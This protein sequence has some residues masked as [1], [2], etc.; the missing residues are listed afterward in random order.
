MFIEAEDI[1]NN[2]LIIK[3]AEYDEKVPMI[4]IYGPRKD[5]AQDPKPLEIEDSDEQ[6]SMEESDE[7]EE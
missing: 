2:K 1:E 5:K 4:K 7:A 6:E 3:F